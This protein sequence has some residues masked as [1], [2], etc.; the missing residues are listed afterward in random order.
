MEVALGTN[1]GDPDTDGDGANDGKEVRWES[2][3]TDPASEPGWFMCAVGGLASRWA[4]VAIWDSVEG[5]WQ[6]VK[7]VFSPTRVFV[8]NM[9]LDRWYWVG[10]YDYSAERW[11]FGEWFTRAGF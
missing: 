11:T 5:E 4:T 8:P 9:K 6:G 7:Y 1:P 10:I 3:P 2:D